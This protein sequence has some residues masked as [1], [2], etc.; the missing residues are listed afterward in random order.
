MW[1]QRKFGVG[2]EFLASLE[3]MEPGLAKTVQGNFRL[4][5]VTF[6]LGEPDGSTRLKILFTYPEALSFLRWLE[7]NGFC[8]W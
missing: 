4:V 5:F 3:L 2:E 7:K 6:E 8:G 1:K